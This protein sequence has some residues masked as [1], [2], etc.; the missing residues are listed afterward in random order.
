MLWQQEKIETIFCPEQGHFPGPDFV[1]PAS[2]LFFLRNRLH[3]AAQ[4]EATGRPE[5]RQRG[6]DRAGITAAEGM[7]EL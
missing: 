1:L 6:S 4:A 3:G 5:Q 7:F 2:P